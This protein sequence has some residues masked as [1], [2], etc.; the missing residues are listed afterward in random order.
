MDDQRYHLTLATPAEG[1]IVH[2][3]WSSRA[4]AER[5][6]TSLMGSHGSM[7]GARI[8]LTERLDG[9]TEQVR[10]TWPDEA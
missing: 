2:G 6:F 3:W 9:E 7:P 4:T 1:I 10:Q 8:T 5:N